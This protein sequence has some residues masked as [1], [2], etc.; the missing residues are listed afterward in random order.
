MAV[1]LWIWVG[2]TREAIMQT[3][4]KYTGLK[5]ALEIELEADL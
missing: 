4:E 1:L 5:Q 2:F 3:E